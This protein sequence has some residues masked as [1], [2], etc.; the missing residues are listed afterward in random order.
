[1]LVGLTLK[2]SGGRGLTYNS[3]GVTLSIMLITL[4]YECTEVWATQPKD[5]WSLKNVFAHG[6]MSS[7]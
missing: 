3:S 4:V 5:V 6:H 1:M 7:G 2:L